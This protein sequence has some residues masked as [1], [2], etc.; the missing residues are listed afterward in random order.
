VNNDQAYHYYSEE[1]SIEGLPSRIEIRQ[2]LDIQTLKDKAAV[3]RL[4]NP[5]FGRTEFVIVLKGTDTLTDLRTGKDVSV[6]L[7]AHDER[8]K[9][10]TLDL[11]AGLKNCQDW[12]AI[13]I[14]AKTAADRQAL[15]DQAAANH[16]GPNYKKL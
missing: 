6:Y 8:V 2:T 5:I 9:G 10:H 3:V 14:S 15:A 1:F 16:Q 13:T 11:S 4:E 12:G 7:F